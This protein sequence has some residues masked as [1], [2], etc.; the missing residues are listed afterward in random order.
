MSDFDSCYRL[1]A[2]TGPGN[3]SERGYEKL[4]FRGKIEQIIIRDPRSRLLNVSWQAPTPRG[5]LPRHK[6]RLV[7]EIDI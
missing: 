2:V 6:L 5:L 4:V 3:P 7:P 1:S